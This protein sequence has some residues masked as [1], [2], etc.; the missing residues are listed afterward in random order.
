[1]WKRKQRRIYLFKKAFDTYKQYKEH[2][3][4]ETADEYKQK[5]SDFPQKLYNAMYNY[6]VLITD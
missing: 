3:I 2:V 4:K 6:N 1:M 5:Y